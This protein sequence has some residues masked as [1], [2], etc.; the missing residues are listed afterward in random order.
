MVE[1]TEEFETL[2]FA[3]ATSQ[4]E[5]AEFTEHGSAQAMAIEL[6]EKEAQLATATE[7][8]ETFASEVAELTKQGS[9][10]EL[11]AQLQQAEAQLVA[12]EVQARKD[13]EALTETQ[14]EVA[15]WVEEAAEAQAA[16][17]RSEVKRSEANM[18]L[19]S[20]QQLLAEAQ[21]AD[22][23]VESHSG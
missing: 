3:L 17:G 10:L 14:R 22:G 16:L 19:E 18:E 21:A 1:M 23:S 5:V 4:T 2:K 15:E 20:L 7:Q 12:A 8:A 11:A 9:S 6:T 13:T